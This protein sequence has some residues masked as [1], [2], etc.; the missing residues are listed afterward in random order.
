MRPLS[1]RDVVLLDA[2]G[3]L[4]TLDYDRVRDVLRPAG[5][6]PDD[7]ALDQAES[8]AR[9]WADQAVRA[10]ATREEL[11]QGYFGRVLADVGVPANDLPRCLADLWRLNREVGLWRRPVSGARET[12][13][14]LK[15]AGR[16]L[17]VVSNAEGQVEAD[18]VAAGFG[19]YLETVVDSAVVGVSKP[20]PRIFAICLA[21]LSATPSQLLY[22][23]DVPAFD[24]VGA[25]AAGIEPVLLD[26]HGIHAALTDVV[27]IRRFD[28]LPA[29][30]GLGD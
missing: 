7:D 29:L 3:T 9:V 28:E 1:E 22:V 24:V 13:A 18:L 5:V 10:R 2:G 20:D 16:R 27:R 8:Q 11:W 14:R 25:R 23:G 4:L 19:E 21:R 26:P 17:A 15:G 12:L 6:Q 30:L